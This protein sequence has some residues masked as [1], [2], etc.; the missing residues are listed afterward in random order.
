MEP[1]NKIDPQ[2]VSKMREA[3]LS[4]IN[5]KNISKIIPK[6]D[7]NRSN[8][9]TTK[10]PARKKR[11]LIYLAIFLILIILVFESFLII[12]RPE[13]TAVEKITAYIP[14]PVAF[15][16]FEMITYHQ[17]LV[18]IKSLNEFYQ[19][20][21]LN[22][23]NLN[24][25]PIEQSRPRVLERLIDEKLHEQFARQL[26]VKITSEEVDNETQRLFD[27]FGEENFTEQIKNKYQW[28]IKEFQNF[29]LKPLLLKNKLSLFLLD[30]PKNQEAKNLADKIINDLKAKNDTFENLAK[31]YSQDESASK[32]G[33]IG[34]FDLK[35]MSPEIKQ[36]IIGLKPG[37]ITKIK[38]KFGF[39]ILR[40]D[41]I[42]LDDNGSPTKVKISQILIKAVG[43][44][45]YIK[46]FRVN[47]RVWV[48][49]NF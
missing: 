34:Y 35:D 12:K 42:L 2:E 7:N 9:K 28:D 11:I 23:E 48:L 3:V 13:A 5:K 30:H 8:Q 19:S 41:E 37:E 14:F 33:D 47:S 43:L 45:E 18:Q 1:E 27:L 31:K 17:W 29:I 15:V 44:D 10:K 4:F 16:N 20:Q 25:L 6:K 24:F 36:E 40:I 49:I 21:G 22:I 26:D 32:G 46:D 39:H 38:T